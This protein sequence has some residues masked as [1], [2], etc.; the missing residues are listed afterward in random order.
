MSQPEFAHRERLD[1]E[2]RRYAVHPAARN[3]FLVV[4]VLFLAV[5]AAWNGNANYVEKLEAEAAEKRMRPLRAQKGNDTFTLHR[6]PIWSQRCERRGMDTLASKA[7]RDP[8]KARCVPRKVLTVA[9]S[10]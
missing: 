4:T 7:D 3:L 1:A 5:A 6:A 9:G 2:I 8:W 10:A